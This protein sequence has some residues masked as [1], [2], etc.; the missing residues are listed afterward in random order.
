MHSLEHHTRKDGTAF[1]IEECPIFIGFHENRGVHIDDDIFWKKDGSS[2]PV[3]YW[4]HPL[5]RESKTVGAV[6]TFLDISE[7]REVEEAL[8]KSEQ[9]KRTLLEINNAIINNLAQDA[10][11]ASAY[12][13]I[14]RVVPFER[15]AFLLY[16]PESKTL[17]LLSMNGT[18]ESEFFR[19][20]KEYDLEEARI[21]AWVL[22]HQQPS[23]E[24][25]ATRTESR[26]KA[27]HK[28]T[29]PIAL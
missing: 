12:E 17:K 14:Q 8:R 27:A 18:G 3:E 2:F 15:A 20:G 11:F 22:E 29:D 23:R 28:L 25:S 16:Q 6:V 5:V 7:R 10:L 24:V 9:R 19:L 4:S 1:P 21:A 13:A 26:R